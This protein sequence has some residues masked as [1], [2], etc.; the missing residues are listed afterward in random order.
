MKRWSIRDEAIKKLAEP[1]LGDK[2]HKATLHTVARRD[3]LVAAI[4][5]WQALRELGRRARL[6][7]LDEHDALLAQ[8]TATMTARGI[9]VTIAATAAEAARLITK[10]V[11]EVGTRVTKAKSMTSEEVGVNAA[12]EAAGVQVTETDLGELI[13]QLAHQPPSHITAPSLHLSV[14]DTAAIFRD[15]LDLEVPAW[16]DSPGSVDEA[17]RQELAQELS[18]AARAVLRERFLGADVGISGANFLVADTGTLVLVENEGN[19]QLTTT[20]PKRHIVLAGIDKLVANEDDLAVLMRMLPI[21][22]TGQL[23]S[24]YVSLFA[25]RHPDMHVV[26]LDNGRRALMADPELRDLLTCIRCGACMNV[27]PVYRNIGGHAYDAPYPGPI[28]ALLM[29]HLGSAERYGSLPFASSLCGACSETCPVKI[30]L[31]D[32]LLELRARLS[33]DQIGRELGL[34][35][36]MATTIMSRGWTIQA[37]ARMYRAARPFAA[38]AG[39]GRAWQERRDLPAAPA[40]TFRSWWRKHGR[41]RQVA[42]AP[43]RQPARRAEVTPTLPPPRDR[44]D[45]FADNLAALG[46]AGETELHR[47]ADADA[48][49]EFLRARIGEL[50]R[51]DVIIEGDATDK[52]DYQLGVTGAA[53]VIAESGGIVLDRK[54]RTDNRASTLVETHIVVVE[55]G[56]VVDTVSEALARRA[57][58]RAAGSWGDFQVIATGPSRTADIEKVLVIPAHG[59]RRLEVVLCDEP[60]DLAGCR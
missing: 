60:V 42:A 8:F 5:E 23:Q 26:L 22:A 27:C 55:P 25:D 3:E 7:A 46:P 16:I 29:P 56:Q 30:P 10:L 11:T 37:A 43:P 35:L 58:L 18:L 50:A 15:E 59:P 36:G 54:C 13:V 4:P 48:A 33:D 41:D 2:V 53:L 21:S 31:H 57:E 51:E 34:G 39:T 49:L 6:R 20:L 28:G 19:I 9:T 38:L 45:R 40:Q 24:C 47:F 52:R 12:L 1:G 14:E 17:T 32:R 44:L